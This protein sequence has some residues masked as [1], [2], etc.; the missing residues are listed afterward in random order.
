MARYF[1][2]S[3]NACW[4][5][6]TD[7]MKRVHRTLIWARVKMGDGCGLLKNAI[8]LMHCDIMWRKVATLKGVKFKF[9]NKERDKR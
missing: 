8:P 9:G 2:S 3:M 4:K 1:C 7:E 5:N 6:S